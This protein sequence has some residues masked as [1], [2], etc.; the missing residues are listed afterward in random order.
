VGYTSIFWAYIFKQY[1]M[2][3]RSSSGRSIK[4]LLLSNVKSYL[5]S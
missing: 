5:A 3:R 4:I 1:I 2:E